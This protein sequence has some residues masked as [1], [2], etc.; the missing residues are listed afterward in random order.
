MQR[1]SIQLITNVIVS[2]IVYSEYN[3][4]PASSVRLCC[5]MDN[6]LCA[7]Q[8]IIVLQISDQCFHFLN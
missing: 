7:K 5:G 6:K 2:I 8:K 1:D 4:L 3:V